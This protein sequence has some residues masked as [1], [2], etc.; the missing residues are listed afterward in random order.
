MN[1]KRYLNEHANLVGENRFLKFVLA[2]VVVSNIIFGILSY[3]AVKFRTTVL[4]PFGL[5]E[6][7]TVADRVVDERYLLFLARNVFDLA[8]NYTPATVESQYEILLSI[9]TPRAYKKYKPVFSRFVDQAKSVK[10]VSVF[11]PEKIEHDPNNHVVKAQGYRMLLLEGENVVEHKRVVQVFKYRVNTGFVFID[12]FG[13]ENQLK[14]S[15]KKKEA[16]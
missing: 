6:K 10:L 4:V 11:V 14:E 1:I 2:L 15:E 12:E 5:N 9:M 3:K 8:L 16:A 7:I 13:E